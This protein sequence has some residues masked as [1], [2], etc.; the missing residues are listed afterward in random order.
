MQFT[1]VFPVSLLSILTKDGDILQKVP[2]IL[3]ELDSVLNSF[4]VKGTFLNS[5]FM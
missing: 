2:S 5:I 3:T 4:G 1:V